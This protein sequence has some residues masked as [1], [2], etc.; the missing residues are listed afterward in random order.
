MQADGELTGDHT[1]LAMQI[2]ER[3]LQKQNAVLP[4]VQRPEVA[5]IHD[6]F[7]NIS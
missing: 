6:D 7:D 4:E 3:S 2:S 5:Q 1:A